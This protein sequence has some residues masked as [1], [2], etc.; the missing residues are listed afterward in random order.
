MLKNVAVTSTARRPQDIMGIYLGIPISFILLAALCGV[1]VY[2]VCRYSKAKKRRRE[3]LYADI[4]HGARGEQ[5][6]IIFASDDNE[7]P[8]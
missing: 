1:F 2:T 6:Q 7:F 4:G 5:M 3:I 8:F